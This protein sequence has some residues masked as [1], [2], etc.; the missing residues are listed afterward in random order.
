MHK[1]RILLCLKF[2]LFVLPIICQLI[3][4]I[5]SASISLENLKFKALIY[6]EAVDLCSNFIQQCIGSQTMT[7]ANATLLA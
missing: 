3:L 7:K 4:L 5:N 6:L 1:D 2:S